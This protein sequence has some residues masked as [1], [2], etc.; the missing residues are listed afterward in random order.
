MTVLVNLYTCVEEWEREL[1][2]IDM[3]ELFMGA[4]VSEMKAAIGKPETLFCLG[5]ENWIMVASLLQ[6]TLHLSS[7]WIKV[8][9]GN[10]YCQC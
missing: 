9:E 6:I 8:V 4:V 10:L 2:D 5:G 7:E 1:C 3:T